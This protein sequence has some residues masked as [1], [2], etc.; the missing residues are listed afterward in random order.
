LCLEH[1]HLEPAADE[2]DGG[3]ET[4]VPRAHEREPRSD[5]SFRQRVW[6]LLVEPELSAQE[7]E[8]LNPCAT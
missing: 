5:Q 3:A 8:L 1:H 7:D 6:L 4:V 2:E